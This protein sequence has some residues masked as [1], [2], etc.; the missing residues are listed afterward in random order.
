MIEKLSTSD[1]I[2]LVIGGITILAAGLGAGIA[3][4]RSGNLPGD[5]TLDSAPQD[6]AAAPV[7]E[8][9]TETVTEVVTEMV[10]EVATEG[11]SQEGGGTDRSG[12]EPDATYVI[13]DFQ[14]ADFDTSLPTAAPSNISGDLRYRGV[15][16][17]FYARGLRSVN[18]D[19]IP[20]R[21]RCEEM[22]SDPEI[23]V[24]AG[25]EKGDVFCLRTEEGATVGVRVVS[26]PGSS[27]EIVYRVW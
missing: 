2:A 7:T 25:V 4:Q 23:V 19:N 8:T 13:E 20:T 27:I 14:F 17:E 3:L 11:L 15:D 10:T 6:T 1:M 21:E 5:S 9:V 24:L 26:A 22:T 18:G 16:R 12:A